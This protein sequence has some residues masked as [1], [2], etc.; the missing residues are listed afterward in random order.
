L[1]E[2]SGSSGGGPRRTRA[3][4]IHA[5]SMFSGDPSPTDVGDAK[6]KQLKIERRCILTPIFLDLYET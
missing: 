4:A 3:L 1:E 2:D 5:T 6:W